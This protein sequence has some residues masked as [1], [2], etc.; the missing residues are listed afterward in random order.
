MASNKNLQKTI[1]KLEKF[2]VTPCMLRR[3]VLSCAILTAN[4]IN[5][6][7]ESIEDQVT[8]LISEGWKEED[9]LR[10]LISPEGTDKL[11]KDLIVDCSK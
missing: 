11:L 3:L 5:M 6:E 4:S 1:R 10:E 7:A 8:Y 2:G 9:I